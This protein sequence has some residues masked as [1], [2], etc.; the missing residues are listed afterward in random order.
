M[1]FDV[2]YNNASSYKKDLLRLN[3]LVL[4][5]ADEKA[6]GEPMVAWFRLRNRR[7]AQVLEPMKQEIEHRIKKENE[8]IETKELELKA[9]KRAENAIQRNNFNFA[10][11]TLS[12]IESSLRLSNSQSRALE[13]LNHQRQIVKK[14][15]RVAQNEIEHLEHSVKEVDSVKELFISTPRTKDIDIPSFENAIL[16]INNQI[17]A[18]DLNVAELKPLPETYDMQIIQ[19]LHEEI[20]GV[21]SEIDAKYKMKIFSDA[22]QTMRIIIHDVGNDRGRKAFNN[23]S[24]ELLERTRQGIEIFNTKY[25]QI[26]GQRW[27]RIGRETWGYKTV[28]PTHQPITNV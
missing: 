12:D 7:I 11:A 2:I 1:N 18:L 5:L 4:K 13:Q 19:S 16:S 25:W 27:E 17:K 26:T 10:Q 8:Q 21:V 24:S 23:R 6:K 22:I 3:N 20:R 15:I 9:L 28:T 14:E